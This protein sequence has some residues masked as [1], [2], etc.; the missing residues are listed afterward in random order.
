MAGATL[1]EP[2]ARATPDSGATA[3]RGTTIRLVSFIAGSLFS[4]AAAALLFRHLG[5]IETGRYTTAM[6]LGALSGA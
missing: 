6:S 3:V 4:V 5:V 1:S 2:D